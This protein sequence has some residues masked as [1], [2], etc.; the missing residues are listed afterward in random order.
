M[1]LLVTRPEPDASRLAERL[2]ALDHEAVI[3]PLM[4][5]S[6]EDCDPI[7]IAE[8]QAL[9]ATS[10]NGLAG[11][12]AQGA[13]RIASGLPLFA[14]GKATAAAARALGFDLIVTGAG[15][16]HDLVPQIVS[17]CDPHAG[18]LVHLAGDVAAADIGAEL[19]P[20]GFR[21]DAPVVYRMRPATALSEPVFEQLAAGLIDGVLL[22]SPRTATIYVELVNKYHL[23]ASVR[24]LTHYCLSKHVAR[25]LAPLGAIRI[26]TAAEPTL[27]AMLELL[28]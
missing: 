15:T 17:A 5:V 8:A 18:F 26:E 23:S 7:E 12:E 14:V 28:T 27:P 11:L 9:I 19:E 24:Q 13:A 20:H 22:F 21:V 6:F 4:A 25:R 2:A 3:E 1:R 10:R 16:V